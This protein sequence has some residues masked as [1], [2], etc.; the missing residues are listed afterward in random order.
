MVDAPPT[1][2]DSPPD[3]QCPRWTQEPRD[4]DCSPRRTFVLEKQTVVDSSNLRLAVGAGSVAIAYNAMLSADEGQIHVMRFPGDTVST[5]PLV[6]SETQFDN[7][8]LSLDVAAGVQGEFSLA[9]QTAPSNEITYRTF[10]LAGP[11]TPPELVTGG[12]AEPSSIA[13]T[14]APSGEARVTYSSPGQRS[15][16]SKAK[17][18]DGT[19][20]AASLVTTYRDNDDGG[21]PT[22][23]PGAWQVSA[24]SDETGSTHAAFHAPRSGGHSEPRY[25]QLAGTI[26][27]DSKVLDNA[28]GT[29]TSGFSIALGLAGSTHYAAFYSRP[30]SATVADLLLASWTG[31]DSTPTILRVDQ[32]IPSESV[33]APR[34]RVAMAIDRWGLVH[35]VMAHPGP[36]GGAIEYRRQSRHAGQVTWLS[37]IIDQDV[38]SDISGPAMVAIAISPNGRPHIA[39]YRASDN[40]V[41]YATRTDR[42]M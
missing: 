41:V 36:G 25:T 23:V 15:I 17:P 20:Q 14:V 18:A 3:F 19:W 35:L 27:T 7:V 2:E 26:W 24:V 42:S 40:T 9:Y 37:D 13:V 16:F 1:T 32:N 29:G 4:P 39:Y 21:G 11:A 33:D 6:I 28:A 38:V 12:I 5:Q 31:R 8:G 34:Y 10:G 30:Q 22:S